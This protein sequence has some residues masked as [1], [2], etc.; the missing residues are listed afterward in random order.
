MSEKFFDN[1]IRENE[2]PVIFIG[3]GIT[4]RYFQDAPTWDNL[5]QTLWQETTQDESYFSVFHQLSKKYNDPFNIY[6]ELATQIEEKYDDAFYSGVT[7]LPNL[8]PK[9]AHINQISPFRTKIANIFGELN[10]KSSSDSKELKLFKGMLSKARLIVTTNYDSF[11]ENELNRAIDVKV[12]NVGLF[13][14]GNELGVLYKIHGSITDP[15]SIVITTKDYQK[16]ER[17]SAIINAKI[18]SKLTESPI[19]FLGYSLTDKNVQSLL[20]D[21]A[22]NMPFSVDEAA[23]RIGVVQY[24]QGKRD[25]EE[26]ISDT[27]YGVHYTSISTDNFSEIYYKVSRINQGATPIEIAKYQSMI[28]QIITT[29]GKSGKLKHVLTSVG[30]LQNLPEKLK[31]QDIVVALGDSKY[32]YKFP[33]YVDYVKDYYLHP[34]NMPE[35]IALHFILTTSPQSTLPISKYIHE[36]MPLDKKDREKLNKRLE[37]FQSLSNLQN[38]TPIPKKHFSTLSFELNQS[39]NVVSFLNSD[40]GIKPKIKMAFLI[41]NIDKID[42][43][44][45]V[46]YLLNHENDVFLKDT[47][48]RKFLMAY[49]LMTEK[50]YK[51]I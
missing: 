20:K 41:H 5:L 29:R 43:E 16:L 4:Q 13:S 39:D 36:N 35:D 34:N 51:R 14:N 33:D 2:F 44:Q 31:N 27:N 45:L 15:N 8:T 26:S 11:I 30:D 18:L 10:F 22:D 42:A 38:G 48:T 24:K 9:Q 50:I 49:S 7:K 21:L 32:I 23:K 46:E 1:L 37:K 40:D 19:L 17:T 6:T 3:S 25:I 12:G 47:N 28:K